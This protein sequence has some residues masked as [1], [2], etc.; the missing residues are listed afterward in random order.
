MNKRMY[1]AAA[2]VL[3][4]LIAAFLL[5]R[6]TQVSPDFPQIA[7]TP[8]TPP[9]DQQPIPGA[10]VPSPGGSPPPWAIGNTGTPSSLP[11]PMDAQP[12]APVQPGAVPRLDAKEME[13]MQQEISALQSSGK[14]PDP[15]RVEE[16]L[17]TL[18]QTH[19]PIA[20]G[21]NLDIVINNL[22][23]S[24]K[25]QTL[26]LDMQAE[27]NKPGGGSTAKMQGYMEQLN[28]LQSQMRTDITAGKGSVTSKPEAGK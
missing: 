17:T 24:Q 4:L 6:S 27:S 11:A 14:P 18:R 10:I 3:A 22:Q 19:G 7:P 9:M 20:G 23:V 16:M 25:M 28:K 26:A 5:G 21:I 8:A 2:L 12:A 13:R 15:K 1:A